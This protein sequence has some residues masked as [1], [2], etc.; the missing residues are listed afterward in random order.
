MSKFRKQHMSIDWHEIVDS[1][2]MEPAINASLSEKA[3][4]VGRIGLMMLSVGTAAWRVRASM[5]KLAR[6]L[7]ITC[8]ADIGLLSIE[9]TCIGNGETYT[10]AISLNNTG[11][12]TDKLNELENF[13]DGFA[14]RVGKYSVQQF[15]MILDKFQDMKGNYKAWNLGLASALACCAFTFLLG[16]G[17]VEMICAFFGAGIGNFVRKKLLEKQITLFAN[18][19]VGVASACCTY[20]LFIKLAELLMNVSDIH[21]AGYI[22]SMLFV[23]PGF[24]LIT[25]GMDLAKLDL[26]SGIERVTYALLIIL[27]AT[28]TGW[29]SA[30]IFNFHPQDFEAYQLDP[31]LRFAII[32]VTSFCGVYGFSLMFNSTRKMAATAGLIGMIANTLRL[33][34]ID[35]AEIHVGLAAFI[36]ALTAGLLASAIHHWIG[37]PRITLTVP[38][39]VIMVPGMFMYKGIYYIALNDIATGGLWLTKAVLIVT[40]LPLGLIFARIITD[41]NFRKSS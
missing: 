30:L 12:N 33:E 3:T 1:E 5:N 22:C 39:I 8:N 7:D 29:V 31:L 10:N 34:L 24:P 25:G 20:V 28:L 17:I 18:V 13:A 9:Y 41:K 16:G 23:I 36:G 2:S 32:M 19:A 21:Q 15:H 6:A 14:E 38:S 26:R 27:V 11:V 40:A 37:Y 35:M 4:L